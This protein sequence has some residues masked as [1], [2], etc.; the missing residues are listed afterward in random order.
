MKQF[1]DLFPSE[2]VDIRAPGYSCLR[3][4][5]T[6]ECTSVEFSSFFLI[7]ESMQ[8]TC[9][10]DALVFLHEITSCV[11]PFPDDST[12]FHVFVH[13]AHFGRVFAH[14]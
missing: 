3:K 9:R 10:R 6:V 4:V 7:P 12:S 2:A 1:R 11:L 13:R 14:I 8:H 5:D